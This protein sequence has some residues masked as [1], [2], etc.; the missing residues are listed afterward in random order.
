MSIDRIA[1]HLTAAST[2]GP[3]GLQQYTF[4]DNQRPKVEQFHPQE[5]KESHEKH[6]STTDPSIYSK[7]KSVYSLRWLTSPNPLITGIGGRQKCK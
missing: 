7:E 3:P 6:L 5:I 1:T 2:A 4:D